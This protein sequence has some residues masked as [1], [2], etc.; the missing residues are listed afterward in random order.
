MGMQGKPGKGKQP[1]PGGK[2]MG[3]RALMGLHGVLLLLPPLTVVWHDPL[4][5][6]ARSNCKSEV[7]RHIRHIQDTSA[8]THESGCHL[9]A[10]KRG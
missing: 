8:A 6:E 4:G 2:G 3:C 10:P 1:M 5:L 7:Q 9:A